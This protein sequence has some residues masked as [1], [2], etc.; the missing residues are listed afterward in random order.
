MGISVIIPVYNCEPWLEQSV[1]S[2]LQ[3]DVVREVILIDDGSRD[4]TL[5]IIN[6]LAE[7][8]SRIIK[9][10]HPN[11]QNLGR[12]ASRNL[13]VLTATQPWIAFLDADDYYLPN[14]FDGMDW[15]TK[16]DGYYGTITSENLVNPDESGML[17]G[18]PKDIIPEELFT[19]LTKQ[20]ESY[21][22][23][24]SMTVRR[25]SLIKIELFDQELKVGEDTDLIWRLAHKFHLEPTTLLDEPCAVRRVH[26]SNEDREDKTRA[27]FY[28]KW[29]IQTEYLLSEEARKRM[30]YAYEHYK[31]PTKERSKLYMKYAYTKWKLSSK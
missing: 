2:A 23:I 15:D 12:S 28:H 18:V 22:S 5:R 14:R 30:F 11:N 1:A 25:D 10:N 16:L 13:G 3:F 29:L 17:T 19:Y 21:F 20:S 6:Q 4:D 9:L 7:I 26:E 27:K 24:I 31:S 8:D